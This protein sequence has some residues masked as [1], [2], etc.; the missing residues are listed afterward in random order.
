MPKK[1]KKSKSKRVPLRRKYKIQKK[2]KEHARKKVKEAKK[3]KANGRNPS[4]PKD[5]GIPSQWPFKEDLMREIELTRRREEIKKERLKELSKQRRLESLQ[6][7]QENA[8]SRSKDFDKLDGASGA[9]RAGANGDADNTRGFYK[10]FNK[11]LEYSDVLIQVLDARDP[12]GCRCS[13]IERLVARNHPEKRVIL[14]LNK[15]DLVP[16]EVVQ[17]WLKYL[18]GEHPTIA[19][20]CSTQKQ[21]RNLSQG[22]RSASKGAPPGANGKVSLGTEC[23]GAGALLQ[24]LKNYARN[25][26]LKTAITVGVIGLPNVGKSSLINS[27]L[28]T[29][30]VAVGSTPGVTTKVQEVHLD[31]HVKLLDCPGIVFASGARQ[32]EVGSAL[33]NAVKAERLEDPRE[34]VY[35]IVTRVPKRQLMR[36]FKTAAF[37]GGDD[38]LDQVAR[39]SGKLLKGGLADTRTAARMVLQ[40]WNSGKI[41]FF[42]TP[43]ERK[44]ANQE[45][46]ALVPSFAP[47]FDAEEV[48]KNEDLAL[49]SQLNAMGTG[50]A[51]SRHAWIEAA[52]SAPQV[53][54]VDVGAGAGADGAAGPAGGE[55]TDAMDEDDGGARDAM[56]EA[57]DTQHRQNKVLY[58]HEGQHNPRLARALKRQKKRSKRE[59]A[60]DVDAMEAGA[61]GDDYDFA[62]DW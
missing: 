36:A 62:R 30:S 21:S 45:D 4:R 55:D 18:R 59:Q 9:G 25:Q 13:D 2:A 7:V 6:R 11:V 48:Y 35:E 12:L 27:L 50:D 26:N 49:I 20:K 10:A 3:A 42:T 33:L 14:L 46:V 17:K 41:P 43:P 54:G 29:R 22:H 1:S 52:P 61:D 19:F 51:Q 28:R 5:P 44:G 57:A 24:L 40:D 38:F 8:E 34:A 15:V 58:S 32:G 53:A 47:Q 31:K 39:A 60:M 56:R 16:A 37:E 23:L